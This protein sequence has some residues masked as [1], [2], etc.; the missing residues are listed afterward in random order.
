[1]KVCIF[2]CVVLIV[3]FGLPCWCCCRFCS[4]LAVFECFSKRSLSQGTLSTVHCQT[5]GCNHPAS[6]SWRRQCK[7]DERTLHRTAAAMF[8][9]ELQKRR[10]NL[11]IW[12]VIS[13][14]NR[15]LYIFAGSGFWHVEALPMPVPRVWGHSSSHKTHHMKKM[16]RVTF[17]A[18][19]LCLVDRISARAIIDEA[20]TKGRPRLAWSWLFCI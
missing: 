4:F 16:S 20:R 13:K 10:T 2:E 3:T 7:A 19:L 18:L 17:C 8:T 15:L 5:T 9:T 12:V 11:K 1:M 6:H 14:L